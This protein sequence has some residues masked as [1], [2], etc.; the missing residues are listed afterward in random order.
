MA[1][2]TL[3]EAID[4]LSSVA[5]SIFTVPESQQLAAL[6]AVGFI[7]PATVYL[8]ARMVGALVNFWRHN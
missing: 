6:F 1:S 5:E 4:R 7:T 3:V 8:A 2:A